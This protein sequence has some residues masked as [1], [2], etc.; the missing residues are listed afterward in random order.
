MCPYPGCRSTPRAPNTHDLACR[1]SRDEPVCRPRGG[2]L[3]GRAVSRGW[4]PPAGRS[5][6]PGTFSSGRGHV[7]RAGTG[8]LSPTASTVPVRTDTHLAVQKCPRPCGPGTCGPVPVGV[9]CPRPHRLHPEAASARANQGRVTTRARTVTVRTLG[10]ERVTGIE[11]ALSAWEAEVLP[12]N[13]TRV[14][15]VDVRPRCVR[16][17]NPDS[18]RLRKSA[19][20]GASR[21]A[22]ATPSP[23]TLANGFP[24]VFIGV[25]SA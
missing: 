3:V 22:S 15:P 11:P 7:A 23:T 12:L 1:K 19:C 5:A 24:D 25:M 13:Y 2:E 8:I 21:T 16:K 10:L 9:D 20:A 6:R 4:C 14:A 18:G 17:S